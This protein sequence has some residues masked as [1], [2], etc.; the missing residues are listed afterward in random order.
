[1]RIFC[2]FF[3]IS[4]DLCK[5]GYCLWVKG[6]LLPAN[7]LICSMIYTYMYAFRGIFHSKRNVRIKLFYSW[8]AFYGLLLACF[9]TYGYL[10]GNSA[11]S[12][13]RKYKMSK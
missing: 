11:F 3:R 2:I 4:G 7:G 9:C 8:S 10:Y 12:A 6:L 5:K 13:I 1:M